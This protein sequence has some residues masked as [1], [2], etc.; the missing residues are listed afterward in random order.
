MVFRKN[1]KVNYKMTQKPVVDEPTCIDCGICASVCPAN[2]IVYEIQNVSKV[3][4]PEA[5]IDGCTEC[6]DN[7]PTGCI[8]IQK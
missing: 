2:P 7:C 4:H 1:L 6:V 3:I 5:C 8:T